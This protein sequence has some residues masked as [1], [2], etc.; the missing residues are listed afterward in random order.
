MW[1]LII[2]LIM[3]SKV[4]TYESYQ[5]NEAMCVNQAKAIQPI[6]PKE[7]TFSFECIPNE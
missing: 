7:Y 6:I 3:E 1:L 2:T 4:E 5:E